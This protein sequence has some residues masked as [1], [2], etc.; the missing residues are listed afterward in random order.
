MFEILAKVAQMFEI[1]AKVAQMFE[2]LAKVAKF[3][4]AQFCKVLKYF[5]Q[6]FKKVAQLLT[7]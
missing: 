5:S 7:K 2:I 3:L 4:V 1:L 6:I